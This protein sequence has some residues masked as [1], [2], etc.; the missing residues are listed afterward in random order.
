MITEYAQ[1]I[2][3]DSTRVKVSIR[4]NSG[5]GACSA[6]SGC[7][8]GILDRW[9]NPT[10]IMWVES[11]PETCADLSIGDELK[12]GV[13]EGA[14]VRNALALYLIPILVFLAAAG[15]GYQTL[16]EF[17]SVIGGVLGL[18]VGAGLVKYLINRSPYAKDFTPRIVTEAPAEYLST[19]GIS[20]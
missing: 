7:G 15:L 11:N 17:A 13:E 16:G 3:I 12:V 19:T 20:A 4:S 5:C 9:L 2:E 18:L 10:R 6:K 8:N 1:V 14:F